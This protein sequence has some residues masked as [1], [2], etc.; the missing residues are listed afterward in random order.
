MEKYETV[1]WASVTNVISWEAPAVKS[2]F[3]SVACRPLQ[4]V[5]I[6]TS[7]DYNRL[8]LF[9]MIML[10][11]APQFLPQII[12]MWISPYVH[13]GAVSPLS[14][15]VLPRRLL[16]CCNSTLGAMQHGP[17]WAWVPVTG[18]GS[19][20]LS[21]DWAWPHMATVPE[22]LHPLQGPG[23]SS[24]LPRAP[25]WWGQMDDGVCV[26]ACVWVWTPV[27][28]SYVCN[29]GKHLFLAR[30]SEAS[31]SSSLNNALLCP[32]SVCW[33]SLKVLVPA[34]ALL[35]E[36]HSGSCAAERRGNPAGAH[37]WCRIRT[38]YDLQPAEESSGDSI[39]GSTPML[40]S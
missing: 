13:P 36:I 17:L 27:C 1:Y 30:E 29:T 3:Y 19:S 14:T 34:L 10:L 35:P 16:L 21:S 8:I 6:T 23:A 25:L 11:P 39:Q 33:I 2:G 7:Y 28:E 12:Y 24:L 20:L 37:S 32:P 5:S 26:C 4:V 40:S 9:I 18:Y 22:S 38:G 31:Q 15:F